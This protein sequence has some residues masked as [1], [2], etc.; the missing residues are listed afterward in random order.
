MKRIEDILPQIRNALGKAGLDDLQIYRTWQIITG[1]LAEAGW[2]RKRPGKPQRI[3][4]PLHTSEFP[5][6]PDDPDKWADLTILSGYGIHH[7]ISPTKKDFISTSELIDEEA[8]KERFKAS[9]SRTPSNE[10]KEE[11]PVHV[12]RKKREGQW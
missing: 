7:S 5:G 6:L 8:K 9:V 1:Q 12:H 3:A 10:T 2:L 4:R 11:P